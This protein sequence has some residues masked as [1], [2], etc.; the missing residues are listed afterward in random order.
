MR[1]ERSPA[2]KNHTEQRNPGQK[3]CRRQDWSNVFMIIKRGKLQQPDVGMENAQPRH[4]HSC[5]S[6]ACSQAAR[7]G[8]RLRSLKQQGLTTCLARCLTT[9]PCCC[10]PWGAGNTSPLLLKPGA[11]GVRWAGNSHWLAV[12]I[13]CKVG[14]R[15]IDY[16]QQISSTSSSMLSN[17]R[18]R[19]CL[20][21]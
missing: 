20:I 9:F 1:R 14:A 17:T 8:T 10:G 6:C 7:G 2:D 19:P 4:T 5:S 21:R 3:E 15:S 12:C 16:T 13:F 18:L 11:I